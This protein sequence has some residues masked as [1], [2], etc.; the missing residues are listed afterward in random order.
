MREVELLKKVA[1]F[2]EKFYPRTWARY[3]LAAAPQT[4][5]LI[6]EKHVEIELRRDYVGMQAMLYGKHPTFDE[7]L[8]T[9]EKLEIEIHALKKSAI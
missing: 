2:K 8:A 5:K 9:L 3:D 6:P 4:L 7:I 1:A